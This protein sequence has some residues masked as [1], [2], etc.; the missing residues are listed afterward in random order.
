MH[1]ESPS[2]VALRK[3][4][5]IPSDGEGMGERDALLKKNETFNYYIRLCVWI[6]GCVFE[7]IENITESS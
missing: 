1:F 2:F 3:S 6:C 5:L 4:A 7:L